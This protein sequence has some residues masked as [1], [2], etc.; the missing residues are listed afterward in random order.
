MTSGTRGK[1]DH[2]PLSESMYTEYR[3]HIT[4]GLACTSSVTR[5]L[6]EHGGRLPANSALTVYYLPV[7]PPPY[8]DYI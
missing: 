1:V 3:T 2:G 7:F 8:N 6:M 4:T 5:E